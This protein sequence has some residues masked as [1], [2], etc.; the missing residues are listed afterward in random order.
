MKQLSLLIIIHFSAWIF[1]SGQ[2]NVPDSSISNSRKIIK[3]VI[4]K[5]NVP[6]LSVTLCLGDSTAWSEGFG[7][8]D[9][10]NKVPVLPSKTKF[11]VASISKT[12]TSIALG[13]L[14]EQNKINIDVPIQKYV[15]DFP[16]KKYSV[17]IRQ[18]G[19][20]LAGIRNYQGNE[21]LNTKKF[22]NMHDGLTV[23]MYD[24]LQ[25]KPGTEFFYSNYGWNL[26]GVA[27]ENVSGENFT[28]YMKENVFCPL[29]MY[30]T[31]P[32]FN[33]SIIDNRAQFYV[34]DSSGKIINAPYVDNSYKWSSGGYLS[35]TSDLI[36]FGRQLLH[37]EII[38]RTTF[39]ILTANQKTSNG[40]FTGY[41][42]G[43]MLG[44]ISD[45]ILFYGHTGTAVGGK[46]ILVM[47]PEYNLVFALAANM[48]DID[49]G[50][51]YEKIV[52]ILKQFIIN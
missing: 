29:K 12:F 37:P 45:S 2:I 3:E 17:S 25:L 52:D 26:I 50:D 8:A 23:F 43:W 10:E 49:F 36:N 39:E 20:H 44:Y 11:R 6:G 4:A 16:V 9:L 35:T 32:D 33:D 15:P 46:S 22:K 14:I 34:K 24:S 27:I 13:I 18:L 47:V 41:G 28:S 38:S 7:Y 48:D 5:S 40:H 51:E 19:G 1:V 31:I 30:S 42:I 21:Y